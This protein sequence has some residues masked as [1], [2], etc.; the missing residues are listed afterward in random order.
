VT[1][2][3][4]KKISKQKHNYNRTN[5][6]KLTSISTFTTSHNKQLPL[7]ENKEEDTTLSNI[8]GLDIVGIKK[9]I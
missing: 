1:F 9:N 5:T 3:Y 7:L 4:G 2:K 6:S 8:F